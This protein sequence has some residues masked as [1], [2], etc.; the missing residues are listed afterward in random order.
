MAATSTL[1]QRPMTNSAASPQ[2]AIYAEDPKAASSEAS[3]RGAAIYSQS[4]LLTIYD[5][6][7]LGVVST[8]AWACS[9]PQ[10]TLPWFQKNLRKGQH[11]DIG[12]GTGYYL[13]KS[14]LT[15]V[16]V[17]LADLN[18]DALDA[19][20]DRLVLEGK[21][22]SG[23]TRCILHDITRPLPASCPKFNSMSLYYLLHCMPGPVPA[24]T[25][26]FSH[27]KHSLTPD[28]VISGASI[29]GKD[30]R[31]NLFGRLIMTFG[32]WNG[33]F[34]N[35]GDN[36]ADFDDAL[37]EHFDDVETQVRGAIFLWRASKPKV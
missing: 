26:I 12:V 8:Y 1:T 19:T 28:G 13:A 25:V 11:L 21:V 5:W 6:W 10:Y 32:N 14:D 4:W 37:R 36:A 3:A 17:T 22:K 35:R 20:R 9:V 18:Q 27:L 23:E 16:Q 34:D 15:G 29:L 30:V 31:H 24:K 33:M 7:V 2:T